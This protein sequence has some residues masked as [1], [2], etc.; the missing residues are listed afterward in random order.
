MDLFKPRKAK[1]GRQ[2]HNAKS[3]HQKRNA[4]MDRQEHNVKSGHQKRN[5]TMDR[6][7]RNAMTV[8]SSVT[9]TISSV[10]S[11]VTSANSGRA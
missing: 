10:P 7:E 3:G 4:T 9:T 8:P 6:Q 11:P 2:E 5:A 1:P